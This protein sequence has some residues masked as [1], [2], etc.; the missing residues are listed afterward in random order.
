MLGPRRQGASFRYHPPTQGGRHRSHPD[1]PQAGRHLCRRRSRGD[2]AQWRGRRR[3]AGISDLTPADIVASH[4][5]HAR[6]GRSRRDRHRNIDA[7]CGRQGR[8]KSSAASATSRSSAPT[9]PSLFPACSLDLHAGEI[10]AVAG[11]DGNGQSEFV[12]MLAGMA[13]PGPGHRRMS[14]RN[15]RQ[16]AAGAPRGCAASASRMCRRIAAAQASSAP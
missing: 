9:A 4:G 14:R 13:A 12:R 7:S 3:P 16:A 5:R 1:H 2:P 10:V 6:R 11:V 15:L 8:A